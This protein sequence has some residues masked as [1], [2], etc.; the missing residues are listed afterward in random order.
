MPWRYN[1]IACTK[2]DNNNDNNVWRRIHST[3]QDGCQQYRD[4]FLVGNIECPKACL[5]PTQV[6]EKKTNRAKYQFSYTSYLKQKQK[7]LFGEGKDCPTGCPPK[8][9]K[10]GGFSRS[11]RMAALKTQHIYSKPPCPCIKKE[12][13]TFID[14]IK[15]SRLKKPSC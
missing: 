5:T 13:K 1:N 9:K 8:Y 4:K 11:A 12:T 14:C 6:N 10:I 2:L 15:S 7:N 3:G